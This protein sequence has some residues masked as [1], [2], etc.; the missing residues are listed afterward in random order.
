MCPALLI[1]YRDATNIGCTKVKKV[2]KP[3]AIE[4][5]PPQEQEPAVAADE[6]AEKAERRRL[7]QLKKGKGKERAT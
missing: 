7:R 2:Q 3:E 5:S 4:Q 1:Q 6:D